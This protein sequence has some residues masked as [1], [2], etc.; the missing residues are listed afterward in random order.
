MTE[1]KRPERLP[2]EILSDGLWF[3]R[4]MAKDA[5][6]D[7]VDA[8]SA[9]AVGWCLIGA[10]IAA[11]H[12]K[13]PEGFYAAVHEA[14]SRLE[15][16]RGSKYDSIAHMLMRWNDYPGRTKDEVVGALQEAEARYYEI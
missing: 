14:A 1:V 5:H 16:H 13:T 4:A 6:G 10:C 15:S 9:G 12:S 3:Q 8:D 7:E 2:S 11:H